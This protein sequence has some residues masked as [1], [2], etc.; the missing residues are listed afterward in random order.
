MWADRQL[1]P[2]FLTYYDGTLALTQRLK[3][4][5]Y[6]SQMEFPCRSSSNLRAGLYRRIASTSEHLAMPPSK[7]FLCGFGAKESLCATNCS[8]HGAS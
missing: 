1:Y 8:P 5:K 3:N 6:P 7:Y 2:R 4:N